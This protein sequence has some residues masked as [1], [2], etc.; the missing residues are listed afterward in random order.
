M[1]R[2]SKKKKDVD[3]WIEFHRMYD[4]MIADGRWDKHMSKYQRRVDK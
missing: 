3:S 1:I 4:E 2:T